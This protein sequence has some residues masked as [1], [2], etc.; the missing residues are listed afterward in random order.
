MRVALWAVLA[1]AASVV[2]AVV[3]WMR[4]GRD[5]ARDTMSKVIPVMITTAFVA[6]IAVL[7]DARADM[8]TTT[9][10]ALLSLTLA[11][12]ST[13]AMG[14]CSPDRH[15]P[16]LRLAS[17]LMVSF[18]SAMAGGTAYL[19]YLGA[20]SFG[21]P[22]WASVVGGTCGASLGAAGIPYLMFASLY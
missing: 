16:C 13:N 6:T 11:A 5:T 1:Y 2:L 20:R 19:A 4:D 7:A 15:M 12:A 8:T 14:V 22:I 21:L 3:A 9:A 17:L 10:I 18:F